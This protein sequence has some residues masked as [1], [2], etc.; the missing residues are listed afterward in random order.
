MRQDLK[1]NFQ[2]ITLLIVVQK[3]PDPH[4]ETSDSPCSI[5]GEITKTR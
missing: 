5:F 2:V 4:L 1:W 3:Y